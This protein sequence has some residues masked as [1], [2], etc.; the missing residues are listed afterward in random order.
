MQVGS[1]GVGA[2]WGVGCGSTSWGE[3]LLGYHGAWGVGYGV[4]AWGAGCPQ[5]EL[6]GANGHGALGCGVRLG[7]WPRSGGSFS[8]YCSLLL[9][10]AATAHA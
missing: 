1:L 2:K 6:C 5:R 10:K 7:T 8:H 3:V 9:N 4:W